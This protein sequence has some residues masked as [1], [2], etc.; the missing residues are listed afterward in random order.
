M[1]SNEQGSS[2]TAHFVAGVSA[3]LAEWLVGHPLDTI[4]VRIMA[5]TGSACPPPGAVRQLVVGMSSI[6]G[7][8]SLYRGSFSEILSAAVGGS[9]LFGVN[10]LLRRSF[11]ISDDDSD[12]TFGI[13]AAAGG[14]GFID[15]LVYKPLEVIKLRMQ[16]ESKG[17]N[18]FIKF[19]QKLVL[20]HGIYGGLYRGIPKGYLIMYL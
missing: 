14:T 2:S 11:G 3:G 5:R 9:L 12:L 20:D 4:R 17:P 16:V 10:N 18:S 6:R 1:H 19:T 13:L 15:A 7:I 8:A